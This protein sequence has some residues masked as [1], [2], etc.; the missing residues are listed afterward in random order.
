[1]NPGI[2][3]QEKENWLQVAF[4]LSLAAGILII[5]FGGGIGP[6]TII[7]NFNVA[8][9]GGGGMM[10]GWGMIGRGMMG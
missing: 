3:R 2:A 4:A 6:T 1:M 10:E 9:M 7:S 5:I 8:P